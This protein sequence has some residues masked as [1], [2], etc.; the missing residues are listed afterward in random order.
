MSE[1]EWMDE[2]DTRKVL[3]HIQD[4]PRHLVVKESDA[5]RGGFCLEVWGYWNPQN[6]PRID[7]RLESSFDIDGAEA[8]QL[9]RTL[10]S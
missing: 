4:G 6:D 3:L 1:I 5:A 2:D 8:R 7:A 9:V 10:M